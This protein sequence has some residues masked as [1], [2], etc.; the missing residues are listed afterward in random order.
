MAS[1]I[2]VASVTTGEGITTEEESNIKEEI[3]FLETDASVITQ[4]LI[5]SFETFAGEK[6]ADGDERK[7]F[8]QGF[9][10]VLTDII[11]HINETGRQNLL[12]YATGANL[13]ALGDLY[14]NARLS[15]Y[16]AKTTLRFKIATSP[17]TRIVIPKG[18]RATADGIVFFATDEEIVFP[19]KTTTL[20][21]DVGATATTVGESGNNIAVGEI[22]KLVDGIA[23][24]SSVENITVSS[25]GG[26]VESD[27][28]YK[29]RLKLSPFSFSVAGPSN[30]YKMIA[31]SVSND[32]G[33]V[34]VYSPS[35]GV[36]EIAVLKEGGI[37]PTAEDEILDE[38]LEACN[39][40]DRRPLT[41]KVQV[42]PAS[43][44]TTTISA[45]Y[46]VAEGDVSKSGD[47]MN[48]VEEYKLWQ[49]E[50]IGRDINPDQLKKLM[51]DAGAARVDITSP[52]YKQLTNK[53]VASISTTDVTYGGTINT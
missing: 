51:M 24:V 34:S 2:M 29:E 31:L 6:L 20:Q 8:L 22:N 41:D 4:N 49:T 43:A 27:E 5:S 13:D 52:V 25:G 15:A 42:V 40:T 44:V 12:E 53:Q 39:D 45:K 46:Y 48:A 30:A 26:D 9:G 33:D 1:E 23:Y 21:L 19:E 10:Y 38:I 35:A 3:N 32:V 14:G 11:N 17:S 7:I 50:K 18:T 37:V 47:I 16:A 28:E 36:V